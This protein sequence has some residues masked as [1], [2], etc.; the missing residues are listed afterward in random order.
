MIREA[1]VAIGVV[2]GEQVVDGSEDGVAGS[3]GGFVGSAAGGES[4]GSCV[5][6]TAPGA[7]TRRGRPRR[8]LCAATCSR[9]IERMGQ[10]F[11]S[12]TGRILTGADPERRLVCTVC[13]GGESTSDLVDVHPLNDPMHCGE[14]FP[15]ARERLVGHQRRAAA[16]KV[17]GRLTSEA[18]PVG[19]AG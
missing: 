7:G 12:H 18:S 15:R 5:E 19:E 17:V 6:V 16:L 11:S 1:D 9:G 4:S 13:L 2:A 3:K 8:G 14:C 10:L